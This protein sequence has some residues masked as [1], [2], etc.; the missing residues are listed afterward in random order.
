LVVDTLKPTILLINP[1]DNT[2]VE[3]NTP[4]IIVQ[5]YD[6]LSGIDLEKFYAFIS[7]KSLSELFELNSNN[8][9]YQ[10]TTENALK[11]G[12]NNFVFKISDNAGNVASEIYGISVYTDDY[13]SK[14]NS[15]LQFL[16][17]LKDVYGFKE[18]L[19]D[20]SINY[21]NSKKQTIFNNLTIYMIQ[22]YQ[23]YYSYPV[24]SARLNVLLLILA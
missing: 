7:G 10:I 17:E 4:E 8:A 5:Y 16:Y 21:R 1:G 22:F 3:T 6:N 19:S 24:Y 11:E 20:L 2:Y 14:I 12:Y 15:A 18:D 13:E 23:K 9:T